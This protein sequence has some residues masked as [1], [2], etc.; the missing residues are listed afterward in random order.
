MFELLGKLDDIPTAF[1]LDLCDTEGIEK[2]G[3]I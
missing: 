3:C 2:S 1:G